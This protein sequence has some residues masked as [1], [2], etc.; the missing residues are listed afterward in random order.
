MSV[1]DRKYLIKNN[2]QIIN[3][4]V[5]DCQTNFTNEKFNNLLSLIYRTYDIHMKI[6]ETTAGSNR[7]FLAEDDYFQVY[8]QVLW[9]CIRTYNSLVGDFKNYFIKYFRVT[10]LEEKKSSYMKVKGYVEEEKR[11]PRNIIVFDNFDDSLGNYSSEMSNIENGVCMDEILSCLDEQEKELIKFKFL[12]RSDG[13]PRSNKEITEKFNISVSRFEYLKS[14]AF[15]K[16]KENYPNV[17][18]DFMYEKS[19]KIIEF[20]PVKEEIDVN[21]SLDVARAS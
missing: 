10:F 4:L 6:V 18:D 21:G 17:L 20:L 19:D 9:K 11:K 2:T 15:K 5:V 13:K 16:I 8:S 3:E 14:K 12:S 1:E 7:N